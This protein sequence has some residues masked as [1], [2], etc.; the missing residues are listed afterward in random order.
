MAIFAIAGTDSGRTGVWHVQ[1][2]LSIS[3]KVM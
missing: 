1:S 2:T 3:C